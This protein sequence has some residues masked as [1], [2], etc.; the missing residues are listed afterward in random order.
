MIRRTNM[1]AGPTLTQRFAVRAGWQ[2]GFDSARCGSF[3]QSHNSPET[4]LN[5]DNSNIEQLEDCRKSIDNLDSAL[6]AIL[7][8]RFRLTEKIG[9]TKA[10]AGLEASDLEREQRQLEQFRQRA[11]TH[12]LDVDVAVDI[13]TRIIHH[14]KDRHVLLQ[15]AAGPRA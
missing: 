1:R 15:L 4:A 2:V 11:E 8:E 12:N 9:K 6:I 7:A 13:M 5:D 10:N 14:A 3:A